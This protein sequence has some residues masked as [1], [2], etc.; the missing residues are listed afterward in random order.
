[1]LIIGG[2]QSVK[3]LISL[4]RMKFTV[5]LFD[6][7]GVGLCGVAKHIQPFWFLQRIKM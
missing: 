1:M 3:I 5:A 2:V 7:V 6:P 4:A